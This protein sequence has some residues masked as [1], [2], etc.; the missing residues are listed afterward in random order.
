MNKLVLYVLLVTSSLPF[1]QMEMDAMEDGSGFNFSAPMDNAS[2]YLPLC[3]ARSLQRY[4]TL[5]LSPKDLA[6]V[7]SFQVLYI[8]SLVSVG[9][10]L[11]LAIVWAVIKHRKLQTLDIAIALQI[12]VI[13][14][15][16]IA[17]ILLPALVNSAAGKWVFGA[18]TCST[19]G[20]IEHTL[21]S[22]RRSLMVAMS[23][24]RFLLVF[25]PFKYPKHHLK[26]IILLSGISWIGTIL[27][28]TA[29]LPGIVDC[30]TVATASFFCTF[31]ATC[32][33]AC[34]I[35][36][37]LDFIVLH[38]PFY[39]LPTILY[40][41]MYVKARIIASSTAPADSAGENSKKAN[42][43]FF[44]LFVTSVLCNLPNIGGILVLQ[45][46]VAVQGFSAALGVMLFVLSH[47]IFLLVVMDAVVILRNRDIKEVLLAA[48]K[49]S[50]KK[51]SR[52]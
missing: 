4:Y 40:G 25:M 49:D 33:R 17:V 47:S 45:V 50:M 21:R 37:Y 38:A 46:V 36:G 5:L 32:S 20:Y 23:L 13:S 41:A 24:D 11:N 15:I 19:L 51:I 43:T 28:R 52:K 44:L 29:G 48:L 14:L 39:V 7:R 27:F 2:V 9:G 1:S 26:A 6:V 22:A 10:V 12:V 3:A 42:I 16:T 30:Y 8:F 35:F 18:Y 31:I 34:T